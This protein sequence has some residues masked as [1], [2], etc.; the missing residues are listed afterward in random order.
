MG[1][2]CPAG[3]RGDAAGAHAGRPGGHSRSRESV[4]VRESTRVSLTGY[5]KQGGGAVFS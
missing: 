2:I 5:P 3:L 1:A 4:E